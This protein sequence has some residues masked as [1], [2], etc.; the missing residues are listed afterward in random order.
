MAAEQH[1]SGQRPDA[2]DPAGDGQGDRHEPQYEPEYQALRSPMHVRKRDGRRVPFDKARIA[3]AVT[4]AQSAV[5]EQDPEFAAAVADVVG[6]GMASRRRGTRGEITGAAGSLGSRPAPPPPSVEEIQDLVEEALVEMGRARVAKAYILYRDRRARARDALLVVDDE[7]PQRAASGRMPQVKDG[8]G[9]S[10]WNPSRIVAALVDEAELPRELAEQV[11]ERVEARVFDAGLRRLSTGLVR[12]I[13]DNELGA[14]GL[15][16]ALRRQEPVGLPR[17]DLRRLLDAPR[18]LPSEA[19][20]VYASAPP[21]PVEA[22]GAEV[23]RRFALEDVLGDEVAEKHR[24]GS[25]FVEDLGAPHLPLMRSVPAEMLLRGE[26]TSSSA[27]D[28]Q[29]E[30]APLLRESAIGVVLEDFGQ[31]LVGRGSR[32]PGLR[33]AV[34]ALGALAGAAGK[35]LDL[36]GPAGSGGRGASQL[37]RL[38]PALAELDAAGLNTPRVFLGW[39]E[40]QP[41]IE[42][43][44]ALLQTVERLLARGVIVPVWHGRGQRWVA[45][46]CRRRGRER[47]ALACAG[48]VSINLPRLARRAGPWRE[49]ALFEECVSVLRLAIEACVSIERFQRERRGARG[50]LVRERRGFAITPVGLPEALRIL[51]DGEPRPDSGARLLGFLAE[52]ARRFGEEAGVGVELSPLF[53]GAA[54]RRFAERDERDPRPT[55]ARLFSGMPAP[56]AERH[57]QY[58]TGYVLG[59]RY[60]QGSVG[61]GLVRLLSGVR[62]GALYPLA[63]EV[64]GFGAARGRAPGARP[65]LDA[66]EEFAQARTSVHPPSAS[67]EEL[68]AAPLFDPK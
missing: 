42:S 31:L 18:Q 7:G 51:G 34:V 37:T 25:L 38:M 48:A 45:P 16:A 63:A 19:A 14:M 21:G 57:P 5:G 47:V 20:D 27:F 3:A 65:H 33:D 24:D 41:S 49:D 2:Q 56:E 28:V 53:G 32:G 13:V 66:W 11:A 8:G 62:S 40:L 61:Q 17:H 26:A 30:L 46:G 10:P 67:S 68:P 43:E 36:S 1:G 6:L 59:D 55:Q 64:G 58:R 50:E 39:E 9:T 12:E 35:R 4:R 22:A 52:A 54:A 23:L 29:G 60:A 15:D 44:P